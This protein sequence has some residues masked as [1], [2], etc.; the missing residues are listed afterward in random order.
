MAASIITLPSSESQEVVS[1]S[2]GNLTS[3]SRP[4]FSRRP[5]PPGSETL[6]SR[7][8]VSYG[9][10]EFHLH[11]VGRPAGGRPLKN[12]LLPWE[13]RLS[14]FRSSGGHLSSGK[15]GSACAIWPP[16]AGWIISQEHLAPTLAEV[17]E[18][19]KSLP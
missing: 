12:S 13:G 18:V 7:E 11:C 1:Q 3:Y 17:S 8:H 14:L 4:H 19:V 6:C 15:G 10:I 9:V 2:V 16:G 5:S